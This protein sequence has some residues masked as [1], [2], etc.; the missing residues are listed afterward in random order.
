MRVGEGGLELE[1][2]RLL[3][4]DA[5]PVGVGGPS[6]GIG[7]HE[8][9]QAGWLGIQQADGAGKPRKAGREGEHVGQP[10]DH[11]RRGELQPVQQRLHG[12]THRA[13]RR[14]ARR[15]EELTSAAGRLGEQ[16]QVETLV[17]GQAQHVGQ[18]GEHL[19][20]GVTIPPLLQPHQV[21]D[22]DP[23][24]RG[25][26]GRAQ[27]RR[28][29]SAATGEPDLGGNDRF[30]SGAQVDTQLVVAHDPESGGL[31]RHIARGFAAEG[32]DVVLTCHR[33]PDNAERVAKEIGGHTLV[34]PYEL[35]DTDT[36]GGLVEAA[37]A[38][39]GRIDV[40]VNNAV[41]WGGIAPTPDRPF[42]AVPDA[43]WL[44]VLRANAEG[45]LRLSRAV[46][47][48]H[49][50]TP[51]GPDGAHLLHDRRGRYGRR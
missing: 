42:E 16:M 41:H 44:K 8:P 39:T 24:E 21:L 1:V 38:W 11:E 29:A 28:T 25:Q 43:D 19:G 23:G 4:G 48:R 14:L 34:V 13:S 3:V 51:V 20:G 22:A 35:D 36:A 50:D 12:G 27:T 9:C 47:P 18:R 2:G 10:V 46:A 32:A 26:L 5:V 40:L 15:A 6:P 33:S 30:A 37:L 45:A 31:S 49:A 17:G 7:E